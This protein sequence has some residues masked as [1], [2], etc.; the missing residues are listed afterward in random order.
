MN[1]FL[2]LSVFAMLWCGACAEDAPADGEDDATRSDSTSNASPPFGEPTWFLRVDGES[3]ISGST[4]SRMQLGY[5]L[6][7]TFASTEGTG[8]ITM[9]GL[10]V[11]EVG[12]YAETVSTQFSGFAGA[13]NCGFTSNGDGTPPP[14]EI[15]I[16]KNDES[17]F[18]AA[19]T[20]T[21]L[22]CS[23]LS[24]GGDAPAA[25]GSGEIIVD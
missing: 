2:P 13:P 9:Q 4:S 12:T 16:S 3:E 20:F 1:K 10:A 7:V 14:L 22:G 19:F 6:M 8:Q 23:Q 5:G 18:E 17:G 21:E 15:V 25:S 11:G 24:G